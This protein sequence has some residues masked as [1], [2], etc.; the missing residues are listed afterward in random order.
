[1]KVAWLLTLSESKT[2]SLNFYMKSNC[3]CLL[4]GRID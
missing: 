3:M 4:T 1:M 2:D